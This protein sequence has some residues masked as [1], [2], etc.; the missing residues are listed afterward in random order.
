MNTPLDANELRNK[1]N[2]ETGQLGWQELQPHYARGVVVYVASGMDLVN[3][4][5]RLSRDD[6]AA[7]ERWLHAGLVARAT[8]QQ[9]EE[10]A[11]RQPQFWSVVVAPWVLVQE[12]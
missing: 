2:S 11:R 1:L 12:I 4:A 8:D 5:V 9:A 6:K 10:W 3:V 7:L